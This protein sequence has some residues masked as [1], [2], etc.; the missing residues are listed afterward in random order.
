MMAYLTADSI[1]KGKQ[2]PLYNG[3][4]M[5]RDWTYVGDIADGIIL[6][7]DKPLG[8]EIINLGR[9]APVK[10][11][12]FIGY[13]EKLAGGKGNFVNKPKIAADVVQTYANIDKAKKLLG[14]NPQVSVEEGV[15]RFWNW[16]KEYE[17]L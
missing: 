15:T 4:E 2:I 13:L 8:Y 9:G 16:Y 6:A 3:G 5:W 1:T 10:L 11:S 12:E 14:Y 7:L 17:N